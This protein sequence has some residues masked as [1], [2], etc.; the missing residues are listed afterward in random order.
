MSKIKTLREQKGI[1][2]SK[3]AEMISENRTTVAMWEAGKSNPRA[4]KLP[5][6]AKALGCTVDEL[7]EGVG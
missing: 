3:F 6:L 1:N 5:K 7:L 4:D 2:Q